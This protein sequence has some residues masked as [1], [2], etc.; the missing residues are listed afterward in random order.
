[1]TCL[2]QLAYRVPMTSFGTVR[3]AAIQASSVIL[4]ADATIE[5]ALGL[6][7]RA[8][9]DGVKLAV[10][11]ETFVSVYPSGAWGHQA[12]QF[13]GFDE[14]WERL[15]ASSIEVPGPAID[16]LV[17]ACAERGI[18]CALGINERETDRPGS[19]YNSL[20]LLGPTGVLSKHRKLV[21]TMHERL[22]HGAGDGTDLDV[23]ETDFGR[24]GGLICWEN[25]MPLARYELYQKGVQIWVAPTADDSE[26]W[27]AS[28]QHIAIESGAFVISVPQYIERSDFPDDFPVPLPDDEVFGR[29]GAAIIEPRGGT[30]IAGP[31]YDEEGIVTA[32]ID[33]KVGLSA[34]RWFDVVGHYKRID[35]KAPRP[36]GEGGW[37]S[38]QASDTLQ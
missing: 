23:V 30:V 19:L 10:F 29:G 20:V 26:G 38:S 11:P 14:M 32:E 35:T 34:K 13:G 15:W 7:H 12:S 2:L 36:E 3:V 6:L 18:Y 25:R 22:F 17:A 4:D 1:M 5:K 33:L 24:I 31:L 27:L 21:P 28:M 9:D 16:K 8:A 37:Q